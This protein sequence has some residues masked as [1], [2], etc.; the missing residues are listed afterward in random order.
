MNNGVAAAGPI[1]GFYFSSGVSY[2]TNRNNAIATTFTFE[3]GLF[4]LAWDINADGEIV[5][6]RGDNAANTVGT[7][8]NAHGFLRMRD[9]HFRT[10]DV[11]GATNTQ[12]FGINDRRATVGQYT[13]ATGTHG[14]AYRVK[15]DNRG[16]G[17]RDEDD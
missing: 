9:G 8:V 4:T 13:D 5:G 16:H 7:P 11:Q 15:R 3:G 10:L 2:I 6:V 12:V 17:G 1:V 14:F